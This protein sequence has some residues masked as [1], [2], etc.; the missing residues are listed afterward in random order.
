MDE[1]END[2]EENER[3]AFANEMKKTLDRCIKNKFPISNAIMEV[4][5][6]KMTY[7]MEYSECVEAFYPVLFDNI[8]NIEGV[9]DD[10]TKRAKAIQSFL[11]E[12]KTFLKDFVRE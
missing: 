8:S 5:S 11:T 12:W 1:E 10:A 6:L 4:K 2:V 3:I 7:N 9:S